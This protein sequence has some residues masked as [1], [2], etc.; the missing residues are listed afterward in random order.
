MLPTL[1]LAAVVGPAFDPEGGGK[2][3][4]TY[5]PAEAPFGYLYAPAFDVHPLPREPITAYAPKAGDVVL[6]SD[7]NRFWTL[8]A[9]LALTGKP[10]HNGLVVT[11]PDGRLGLFEAGANDGLWT[12]ITPLD[13][14]LNAYPGYVWVRPRVVPLTLEQDR[15]LPVRGSRPEQLGDRSAGSAVEGRPHDCRLLDAEARNERRRALGQQRRVRLRGDSLP[16]V[17]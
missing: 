6:M 9:R 2:L 17:T 3:R 1:V 10:G 5:V 12:R 7:T 11:M 4:P 13:Y 16:V 8:L 15:R 14:R